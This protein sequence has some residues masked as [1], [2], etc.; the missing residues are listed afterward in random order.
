MV[1]AKADDLCLYKRKDAY[2]TINTAA[3]FWQ[4]FDVFDKQ[5]IITTQV[6]TENIPESLRGLMVDLF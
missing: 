1:S 3:K 2:E 4:A 5:Y 6:K